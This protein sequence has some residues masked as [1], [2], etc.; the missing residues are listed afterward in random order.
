MK[1]QVLL[2]SYNGEKYISEL[3]D[4]LFAQ[5]YSDLSILIRDDGSEDRTINLIENFAQIHPDRISFFIG[6]NIG[7]IRSFFSL[8]Q[9]SS[10]SA[11]Y[12]AYCDQDDVWKKNK[13]QLAVDVLEK[14]PQ[15][16][17]AMY[18]SRTELVNDSLEYIGFWPRIPSKSLSFSNALAENIAVGCTVVINKAARNLLLEKKPNVDKIIMHDWWTYLL[19]S[20]FGVVVYDKIPT[21]LYRQHD[22]NTIGG[23]I[24]FLRKWKN[25]LLRFFKKTNKNILV[26][27]AVECFRLFG[28]DLTEEKKKVVYKFIRYKSNF[29]NR[30]F[31]TFNCE[32][33]R[34][35]SIEN[36]IFKFMLILGRV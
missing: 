12:Y 27:Q 28:D 26:N 3:L 21:I 5:D 9:L 15:D 19:V 20:A 11:L 10:E 4:S 25:K 32:V 6:E 35:S 33:Y 1:L 24:N 31:Y 22:N 16:V 14:I 36:F 18:C 2:S 13:I 29:L 7:V 8:L 34:Q 17:P 30:I 23:D